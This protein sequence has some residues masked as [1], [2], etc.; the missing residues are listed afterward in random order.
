MKP[1]VLALASVLIATP[2]FAI[3]FASPIKN[4]D[5]TPLHKSGGND[6][7]ILTLGDVAETALVSDYRDEPNLDGAEKVKRFSIAKRIEDKR[8]NPTISVEDIAL[9]KKL[10]AKA[11]NPL[12]T[13]QSW[14][15]L[16]PA[17]APK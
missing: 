10:I 7:P 13:G 2:A 9:I 15:L 12:V 14:S 1:I 4:L 5:G 8:D 3:D 6:G 17:A 16:D 11:Y